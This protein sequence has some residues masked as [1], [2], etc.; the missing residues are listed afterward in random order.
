M[1]AFGW[2]LCVMII[3]FLLFFQIFY[4]QEGFTYIIPY[5]YIHPV[6][7]IRNKNI[8]N[9]LHVALLL[10]LCVLHE[11]NVEHLPTLL[12]MLKDLLSYKEIRN[13]IPPFL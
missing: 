8:F 5:K 13:V 9:F 4:T 7:Y 12:Y 1:A 3:N 10:K 11:G 6:A 2:R